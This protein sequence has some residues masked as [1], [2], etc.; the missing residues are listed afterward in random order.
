MIVKNWFLA[1]VLA[2]GMLASTAS[3]AALHIESGDAG[4][5]LATAQ[6]LAGG[7]N[8][9]TGNLSNDSDLFQFYWGGGA[10]YVNTGGSSSD[11][12]TQLFLFNAS[13]AGVWANDDGLPN[14]G[15]Y[16]ED[17]ALAAG[18]YYLAISGYNRDPVSASGVMFQSSP[19]AAQYGPLF[20]SETLQSWSQSGTGGAYTIQFR[21]AS[22]QDVQT[23]TVPEPGMLGLLGLGLTGLMAIGR[24]KRG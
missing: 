9:I 4:D 13:G 2:L 24:R 11:F 3:M 12:D 15:S 20:G 19:F 14:L 17:A 1:P 16:I 22:G 8:V 7:T 5:T 21:S 10:F 6:V 18:T 23:G